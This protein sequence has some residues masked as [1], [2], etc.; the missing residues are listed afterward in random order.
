MSGAVVLLEVI[1]SEII[2]SKE[3][4]NCQSLSYN[5]TEAIEPMIPHVVENSAD[6]PRGQTISEGKIVF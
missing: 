2:S 6:F 3:K 1:S 4:F 5:V